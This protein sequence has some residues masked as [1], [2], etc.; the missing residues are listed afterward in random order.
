MKCILTTDD[1]RLRVSD[2][3]ARKKVNAGLAIF[4]PKKDWKSNP[5]KPIDCHAAAM[6]VQDQINRA[7]ESK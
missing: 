6:V 4:I 3:V 1:R 5:S 2:D 7:K